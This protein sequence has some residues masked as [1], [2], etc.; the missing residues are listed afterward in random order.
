[1]FLASVDGLSGFK[2]AIQAVFPQTRVQR[3]VIHQIRASLKYVSWKDYKAFLADLK[4]V[5]KAATREEAEAH[6][7]KLDQTWGS[8]YG[9]AVRSWQN[10]W[11]DLATYFEFPAEIRRLIYT[12]NAV[13]AYHR[14]LRKVIKN[15]GSFPTSQAVRKLFY[16]ATMDIEKKWAK[17]IP[18]WPLILNQLAIRFDGRLPG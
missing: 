2:D 17:P 16:L 3:C 18:N 12:T 15:K 8:R 10:N 14:Q 4:T 11:E 7:S 13:E 1:M 5:Y 9:M 6:L